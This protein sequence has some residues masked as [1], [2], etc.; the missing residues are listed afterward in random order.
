MRHGWLVSDMQERHA[1]KRNTACEWEPFRPYAAGP[2]GFWVEGREEEGPH[3]TTSKALGKDQR[4]Q[5][6]RLTGGLIRMSGSVPSGAEAPKDVAQL[7][8]QSCGR[9]G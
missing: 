1:R 2:V 4:W 5:V 9:R 7:A 6:R 3:N 8:G